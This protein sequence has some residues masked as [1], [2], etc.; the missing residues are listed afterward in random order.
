M[1]IG[2]K[3]PAGIDPNDQPWETCPTCGTKDGGLLVGNT[4]T[5]DAL[6]LA[7]IIIAYTP[8]VV[9]IVAGGI[10]FL[11]VCAAIVL[12]AGLNLA[13]I[14]AVFLAATVAIAAQDG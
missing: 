8:V 6:A 1:S 2:I 7:A 3:E 5:H 12:F 9:T 4:S 10:L 14:F 13:A 11:I